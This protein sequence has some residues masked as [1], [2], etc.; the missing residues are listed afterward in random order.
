MQNLQIISIYT[1]LQTFPNKHRNAQKTKI[2][3]LYNKNSFLNNKT[4][5]IVM[6]PYEAAPFWT[7]CMMVVNYVQSGDSGTQSQ[8]YIY[9]LPL[10]Y[11]NNAPL[12]YFNSQ[13][14]QFCPSNLPVHDPSS[15]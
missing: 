9:M 14:W 10:V 1:D 4:I 5:I 3:K 7:Y 6:T 13:L 12:K 2:I 15:A 11:Y 8:A